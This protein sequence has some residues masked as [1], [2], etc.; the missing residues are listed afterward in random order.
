MSIARTV[1]AVLLM[2]GAER[3]AVA[4][5]QPAL[6]YVFDRSDTQN[7]LG[8]AP[9]ADATLST[10]ATV[11]SNTPATFSCASLDLTANGANHNYA[12][13]GSD[14]AKIDALSSM[15]ITFW[16]NLR[17]DPAVNDCLAADMPSGYPAAGTGGWELRIASGTPTAANFKIAFMLLKA[18]GSWN[19]LETVPSSAINADHQWVFLAMTF[20]TSRQRIWYIGSETSSVAS[21]GAIGA[22]NFGLTD[23]ASELR[24]GSATSEPTVDRTPP[25]WIDDFRIYDTVLTVS[26]LD[27]VRREN[28]Q[29]QNMTAVPGFFGL[30]GLPGGSCGVYAQS[31]SADGSTVVGRANTSDATIGYRWKNG[32]RQ[33]LADLA[34]GGTWAVAMAASADGSVA[35]GQA[36]PEGDYVVAVKWDAAGTPTALEDFPGGEFAGGARGVSADGSVIAGFGVDRTG[37]LIDAA[38]WVNGTISKLGCLPG[39]TQCVANDVSRDGLTFIGSSESTLD[40]VNFIWE[41]GQFSPLPDLPGGALLSYPNRLSANKKCVVGYGTSDLGHEAALWVNGRVFALGDLPTGSFYSEA[42]GVSARGSRVV[43][44]GRVRTATSSNTIEAFIWDRAHGMRSLPSVLATD[45]GLDLKGWALRCAVGISDDGTVIAG[46][47]VNPVGVV[48]SWIARLP[49]PSL[50]GDFDEDDDVDQDDYAQLSDCG[51]GPNI[52]YNPNLPVGCS[53]T[54]DSIG[55]IAADL[56]WDGDVDADDFALLQRCYGGPATPVDPSCRE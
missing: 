48:D 54:L 8:A 5:P 9:A 2:V 36:E 13:T 43:G 55:L 51:T 3:V 17:G 7:D 38:Q 1:A 46:Y 6:R 28:L 52:P 50:L 39:G 30:G 19:T 34:G 21:F 23:N 32:V 44:M 41:G 18:N 25:A 24:I 27:A 26:Q 42:Y 37:M 4:Q 33:A 40:Y 12:Y 20:N 10:S 15:T 53:Q 49:A 29:I 47:G 14:V 45:Y 31:I 16:L 11:V 22:H 56:D 35:V